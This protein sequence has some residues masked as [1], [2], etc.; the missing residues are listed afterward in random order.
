MK[1]ELLAILAFSGVVSG[2]VAGAAEALPPLRLPC[3]EV[4]L[5]PAEL[6]AFRE[7]LAGAAE[8]A[9][10]IWVLQYDM[11]TTRSAAVRGAVAE[12]GGELLG[13]VPGGAYLVRGTPA[14]ALAAIDAAG[15]AAARD[16]R[17][18][19]K[20]AEGVEMD[21]VVSFFDGV[22]DSQA[23]ETLAAIPGCEV[24][25]GGGGALRVR[26]TVPALMAI[27][28]DSGVQAIGPWREP[29]LMT[30]PDER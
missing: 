21:A 13:P 19:D 3:G 1:R 2:A 28:A 14:Q 8:G 17:P 23:R 29:V 5:E 4:R 11:E 26:A 22:G 15:I 10:A 27:A 12:S 9:P 20:L 18:E 16:Y 25:G 6:P 7:R 24:L 30:G